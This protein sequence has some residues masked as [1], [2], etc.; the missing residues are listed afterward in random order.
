MIPLSVLENGLTVN[1]PAIL[2]NT[3][4]I[5]EFVTAI[6][7]EYYVKPGDQFRAIATCETS[8]ISCSALFQ[9]GYQDTGEEITYLWAVGEFYDQNY[10]EINLDLSPL[11]GQKIKIILNV[12]FLNNHADN[13]VLWVNPGIYGQL[14]VPTLTP[15]AATETPTITPTI[16][17]PSTLTPTAT[18]TFVPQ[19]EN[20]SEEL[21]VRIQKILHEFF[22]KLFGK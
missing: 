4:D 11:A 10:T 18:P 12:T 20:Q 22:N 7:P 15:E 5:D 13:R 17:I 1:R 6:F 21:L 19:A 9:V 2:I 14:V 8:A 16:Q 3:S